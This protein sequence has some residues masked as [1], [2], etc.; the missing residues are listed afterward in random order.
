MR[1]I[2][3]FLAVL[4]VMGASGCA[5]QQPPPP[6]K[7]Q[8]ELR[9]IQTRVYADRYSKSVMKALINA[10]LDDGYMVR[11]ADKDLGFISASKEADVTDSREQF[12]ARFVDGQYA[13]YKKN[14]T[15]EASANVTEFGN[16]TKVRVTFQ[17][18]IVD[19]FGSPVATESIEDPFYYQDFFTRVDKSLFIERERL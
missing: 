10:L 15:I 4:F 13:R 17:S 6:R 12:W 18:K 5:L 2:T 9:E 3:L 16:E 19:N 14:V 11:N 8:L 7:T 1:F